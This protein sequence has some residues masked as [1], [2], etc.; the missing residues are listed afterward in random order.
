LSI[1]ATT[2]NHIEHKQKVLTS[3][4]KLEWCSPQIVLKF[5]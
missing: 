1:E 4:R 5:S 2:T 3:S